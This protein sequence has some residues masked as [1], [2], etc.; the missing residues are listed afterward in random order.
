MI[1]GVFKVFKKSVCK[2]YEMLC[3]VLN[4]STASGYLHYTS[5][6]LPPTSDD[7]RLNEGEF[8]N[9]GVH[10]IETEKS[11]E[12]HAADDFIPRYVL[13]KKESKF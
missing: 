3:Q 9:K 5:T 13:V 8:L 1:V 10:I 4:K 2:N 6:Q 11:K 7:E 12:K